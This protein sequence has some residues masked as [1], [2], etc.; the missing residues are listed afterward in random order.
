LGGDDQF[1]VV[2]D[3]ATKTQYQSQEWLTDFWQLNE[4]VDKNGRTTTAYNYYVVYA[5]DYIAAL[6]ALAGIE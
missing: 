3:A 2:N 6:A 4:T 1:S 5:C